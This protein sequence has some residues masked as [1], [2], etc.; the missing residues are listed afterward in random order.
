VTELIPFIVAGVAIGSIYGMTACG[1]VLTYKTSGIFN[2][3]YGAIATAAAYVFY[4]LHITHGLPWGLALAIAVFAL[5]PV[6]GLV[7]T[8]MARRLATQPAS[9]K[10][11]A[12]IGLILI[13]QGVGTVMYGSDTILV[14]PY[15]PSAT[16]SFEV[17]G[18]RV[19]YAQ[20]TVFAVGVLGIIALFALFRWSRTG[21]RMRAVVDNP[22]LLASGGTSSNVIRRISWIIG[23]TFAALSGVLI[24]PFIGLNALSL[25]LLVVQA[26]G[27]A[28]LGAFSSIPL[29]FC[30]ALVLGVAASVSTKYVVSVSWLSGLPDSVP[31]LALFLVLLVVPR[32]RL[33]DVARVERR[34]RP[35]WRPPPAV[36]AVT[37]V[38]L[39]AVLA[40]VPGFAGTNLSFYTIGLSQILLLLSLGLLVRT[41]GQVSL[42][43]STFGA[44]GAV[45]FSQLAVDHHLPWLI[46]LLLASLIVAVV[47]AVVAIPAMRLS[48]LFLALATLGFG[49]MV[50][51][52]LYSQNFLFTLNANGRA[53]PRPSFASS[54]DRFYYVALM[55]V[56]VGALLMVALHRARLGRMLQGMAGSP[57]GVVTMGLNTNL[58]RL[59]VF[60]V[61][62][63]MAASAGIIYAA[64]VHFAVASDAHFYWFY[65][66]TLLAMLTLAP[67]QEPWYAIF[68]G[69]AA[70]IP[71]YLTGQHTTYW[72]NAIFGVFAIMV[73]LGGQVSAPPRLRAFFDRFAL[74]RRTT[75]PTPAASPKSA[76]SVTDAAGAAPAGP[77]L[78]VRG[79]SVRF[80]GLVA[81]DNA[82]FMAPTGR[83]TG[84]IGPNGAG[85]TTAFDACSGLNRR[86]RGELLLHGQPVTR[87]GPAARARRG[88]GRTFQRTELADALTVQQNVALGIEASR[89]GSSV[90]SQLVGRRGNHAEVAERCA[91]A[92]ALCGISELAD[93]PV[94]D[95]ST[96]QRRLVELARLLAGPFD[97]LLLD[98]PS[99]GLDPQETEAFEAVLRHVMDERSV[100][101]LLVEHDMSL[102][103]RIC[104]YV[105]VL[106]F[107]RKIFE[108]TPAE[109]MSSP[110]VQSAYLGSQ[111]PRDGRPGGRVSA[112][113]VASP[114]LPAVGTQTAALEITG[115]CAGYGRT[116]VL[117]DVSLTVPRGEVTALL[118]PNGAGKSTV[119]RA[120]SGFV[121][122]S[123]GHIRM[124]GEDITRQESHRRAR[125]GL[126]HVPEGRGIFRSLTVRE[127]L[128]LQCA[129][130][131]VDDG[132][133]LA[134]EAFPALGRRLGQLA[135]TLS[136]GEQQMLAMAA[137]YVRN[138]RL[139][140][141]DEPSLGLA[142]MVVEE[143]F[144]FLDTLRERGTSVLVVDQFANKALPL[145]TTAY[146]LRKGR[147][148]HAGDALQ[149]LGHDEL[150][151]QYVGG[152]PP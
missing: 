13:V 14:P 62:A 131:A 76:A 35:T 64:S 75:P 93:R 96:G 73:A 5:G 43:Q 128:A 74:R 123:A 80:G 100:A 44:L 51:Q 41:S 55:A 130:H 71:G 88:L 110:V 49:V 78:E 136:G 135:G 104:D 18:V 36:Q 150:F 26:F 21:L 138:P 24:L 20:L 4:W 48:G 57:V 139:V 8:P 147:I 54:D 107:G 15:L 101:I 99:S 27:A 113:P 109:V 111:T 83:I 144:A 59:I 146:V 89:A 2:F 16:S 50:Q 39:L 125:L 84:L 81:V 118:G 69:I 61:S 124:F 117:R 98:E 67:F 152:G 151:A 68:A 60:C 42:C 17:G 134:V 6:M 10:I 86:I 120:V 132:M 127:N 148:V 116:T 40:A 103:M 33:L 119:L 11:V 47:G 34:P 32:R 115:L 149:L 126:C 129:R 53:V 9:S 46:A 65:S 3:G 90:L 142:P 141:V 31:F 70:V 82:S 94:A 97:V 22:E 143:I 79:L 77:G 56:V 1:L 19:Q 106:D 112:P 122:S 85:K 137:A 95:L 140:L 91:S 105:Y 92:L 121:T 108:G 28:S 7:L 25:T 133:S 45:I 102:V 37:A 30:G 52:L 66:L 38:V 23:S 58:T 12:T 114:G 72:L 87:W 63:F 145:A 29:A